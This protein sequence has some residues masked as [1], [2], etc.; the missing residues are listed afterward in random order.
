MV[1]R[2]E[3][4]RWSSAAGHCGLIKDKVLTVKT[5]WSKKLEGIGDWRE[6]LSEEEDKDKVE[7]RL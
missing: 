2:A 4:Y 3:E 7:I 6:W 5:D 1:K